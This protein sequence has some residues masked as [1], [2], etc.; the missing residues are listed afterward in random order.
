VTGKSH[1]QFYENVCFDPFLPGH[2]NWIAS[3]G[4]L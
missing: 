1:I 2:P 3:Q 4:M